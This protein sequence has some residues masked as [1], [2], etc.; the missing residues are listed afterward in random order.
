S[1]GFTG[2]VPKSFVYLPSNATIDLSSNCFNPLPKE[3]KDHFLEY[4]YF[5][6][7]NGKCSSTGGKGVSNFVII[8][9]SVGAAVVVIGAIAGLLIWKKSTRK[10]TKMGAGNCDMVYAQGI[11]SAPLNTPIYQPVQYNTPSVVIHTTVE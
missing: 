6:L 3:I 1:N 2:D 8:G 10:S 11:T 9:A 4:P 5:G 7:Q